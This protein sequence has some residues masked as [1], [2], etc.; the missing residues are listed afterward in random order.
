MVTLSP[1]QSIVVVTSP[2]GDHAPPELAA[3]IIKPANQIRIFLSLITFCRIVI[4]T[5]VAVRLS[6]MADKMK[7][8]VAKIHSSPFLVV[9]RMKFLMVKTIVFL[10]K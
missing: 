7:A 6:I 8:K 1:I 9:V 3:M 10:E 2:I 5:M 4:K